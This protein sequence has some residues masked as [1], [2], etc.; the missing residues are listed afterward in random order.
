MSMIQPRSLAATVDAVNDKMFFDRRLAAP[1][2]RR[3]AG[4]IASRCDQPRSY[5]QMPAPTEH[6]L[7]NGVYLFTGEKTATR[8]GTAHQLGQE[9]CRTLILLDVKDAAVKRAL[10][11][12]SASMAAR[13]RYWRRRERGAGRRW[14]GE[15]CCG[16]CSISMWRRLAVGPMADIDVERWLAAAVRSIKASRSPNGRWR[17]FPLWYTL[18][19]LSEMDTTA[20]VQEMRYVAPICQRLLRRGPRTGDRFDARRRAVAERVL[21]MC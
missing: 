10:A 20:A 14:S 1:E 8:V 9:A 17:R 13:L 21:A 19:A 16:K 6:D 2:R 5:E 7:A 11:N 18:L 15:Y 4:W 12:A 3:L